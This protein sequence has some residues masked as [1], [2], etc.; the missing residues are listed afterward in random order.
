MEQ[1]TYS[2]AFN[3]MQRGPHTVATRQLRRRCT[4]AEINAGVTLLAAVPGLAYRLI[5][6]TLIAI[7]GAAAGATAVVILGTRSGAVTLISAAVAA[8]TQSTVVKPNTAS[9]TVLADGASF[10][11]LDV[12]TAVTAGKTGGSLTGATNIDVIVS[13]ALE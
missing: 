5:D 2:S 9:V 10:T 13:Y 12:N 7:G 3:E 11:P 1:A 4:A 8:L 6:C